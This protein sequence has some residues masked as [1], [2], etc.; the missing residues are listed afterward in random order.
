M[1][2]YIEWSYYVWRF[3][4]FKKKI[5]H[6][7]RSPSCASR[8]ITAPRDS[9][10]C[11]ATRGTET[12]PPLPC[13]LKGKF[14]Y[15]MYMYINIYLYIYDIIIVYIYI[16]ILYTLWSFLCTMTIWSSPRKEFAMTIVRIA[17]SAGPSHTK[18]ASRNR[19]EV[20]E[21]TTVMFLTFF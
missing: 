12:G 11:R 6:F 21:V 5:G 13:G 9:S 20:F 17:A 16:Y 4:E 19:E 7:A 8:R 3:F 18:A 1:H 2:R 15:H 10:K 14:T